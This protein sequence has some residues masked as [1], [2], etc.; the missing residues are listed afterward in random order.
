MI[1]FPK[2]PKP[3]PCFFVG[4]VFSGDIVHNW[5]ISQTHFFTLGFQIGFLLQQLELLL[6]HEN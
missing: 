2:T 1:F 4:F 5:Q 3:C 6:L